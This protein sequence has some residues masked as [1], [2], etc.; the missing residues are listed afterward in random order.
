MDQQT[1]ENLVKQIIMNVNNGSPASAPA[2]N[3]ASGSYSHVDYPLGEKRTN[4][5]R[6]PTGKGI[7]EITLEAVLNGNITGADVR[8]TPE[9]LEA[10]AQIAESIGRGVFANNLRRAAELIAIPDAR[11]LEMYNAL[12]PYKSTKAELMALANELKTQYKAH[13]TATLVE[14]A[15]QVYEARGRLKPS[16]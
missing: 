1:L 4:T 10:Q 12:R 14:E 2:R 9:T 8:I 15:A 5:L 6:T 3:S 7:N 11:L 16:S 13:Q